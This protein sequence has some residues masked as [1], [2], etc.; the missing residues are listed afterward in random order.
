MARNLE[1]DLNEKIDRAILEE[2]QKPRRERMSNVAL[3]R[4]FDVH[5]TTIRRHKQALQKA[6]RLPVEQDRDEFFDIPVNAITQRRR[7]IRLEDGSYER[8]TYNP[9]V[10]VAEDVRE[11]SYEELEKVFDRAVLAVAPKVEEDRPKTLVVCL[12]DFQVGK[13]LKDDTPVLTTD[14][15]V[16]HGSIRP[17]MSVYGRDGKPKKVLAVTGS[18]EQD[19]YEVE[20]GGGQTLIASGD[21]RWSGYRSM[22]TKDWKGWEKRDMVLST[23]DLA[24]ICAQKA[25]KIRPFKVYSHAP[26]EFES[27][28]LP[29]DPYVLGFWLGDGKSDSGLI[30]KGVLDE[31]HLKSFGVP[32]K[33]RPELVTVR[34]PGLTSALRE[35]GLLSNK[36]VPEAYIRASVEQR[37]ALLQGLMD[38][39]GYCQ[40]KSGAIEFS[41][42]NKQIVNSVVTI[43]HSLGVIPRVIERVGHYDDVTCKTYWRVT[44]RSSLPMFRLVRKGQYQRET[45]ERKDHRLSVKTVTPVGRGSAQCLT[46]EGG[47]YLAGRELTLTHNCDE[48]G[49]TQETVNRVMTTLKRITEWIQAEGS[50]EEIIIADVGDVCEG[51]W[52]VTSQQQTNDLSLT[53]QIR[54]AQRLM[55]EAVAMLAPL[56]TRMTY[57]SIPSNHCAVRTSKGNDNRANSPDDDFGLLIA[58]TIQAIMS[59]REPFSHVNFAKPQ[60]WE[61]AVTVETADGTAVGF[62]HG[63]LAGSQ[64]KIPS[65]FRDLAFGHRSGLHEASILV[66][67]HFHNFGVSL[68]GDNKFIIGCPTAD[69]GSSWFTNR[70]GDAT[71]PALLTFEVQDK[72]AKRWELWY[73]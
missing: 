30:T 49:G 6:L 55:A 19:L 16:E 24:M 12:S 54:V 72:K 33:S 66:H 7:T 5:E 47:E 39:D 53:D 67:G 68:V 22:H 34:V 32:I 10:A 26:I 18:T 56:C 37:L 46:V 28:E 25:A 21:H 15:W 8:V 2:A 4:M 61:E 63:H 44:F 13:A 73:E 58:D 57:V 62:T 40:P 43:L 11:A 71:D 48:Q 59:G 14:G 45:T 64:A 52:N 27:A 41:N 1:D 31:A 51:F 23:R 20:F 69:N 60:K 50:Y 35:N 29:I 70:T 9:A 17:G 65:W 42:T 3:G 38:S 36:H